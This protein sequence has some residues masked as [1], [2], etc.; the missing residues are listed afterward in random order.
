MMS[1]S[2][3]RGLSS[4]FI[5]RSQLE[6]TERRCKTQQD[7]I[8]QLKQELTN[9]SAE[10]KLRLAQTEGAA[11]SDIWQKT[12]WCIYCF[13][14]YIRASGH[15][16]ETIQAGTGRHGQFTTEGG[17]DV[18]CTVLLLGF[19]FNSCFQLVSRWII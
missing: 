11:A 2:G 7:Q 19:C 17:K 16:E 14:L 9:T 3:V 6:E 12:F 15:G 5:T 4:V 8:F 13:V 10:L 1:S 18:K